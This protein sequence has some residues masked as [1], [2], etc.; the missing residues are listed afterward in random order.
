MFFN[1]QNIGDYA[2]V[3]VNIEDLLLE[4][5]K[6]PKDMQDEI[7]L[8][9]NKILSSSKN[10]LETIKINNYDMV[11]LLI[12]ED[13]YAKFGIHKGDRSCVWTIRRLKI[14]LKLIFLG[15]TRMAIIMEN[16]LL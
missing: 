7:L 5:E 8:K 14:T 15:L 3:N 1:L 6:I 10:Y 13:R 9:I 2:V 11:E 4:K 16:V 12:E